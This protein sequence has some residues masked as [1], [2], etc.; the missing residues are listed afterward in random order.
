MPNERLKAL[1]IS[2]SGFIFDPATGSSFNSNAAGL[3]IISYLKAGK[4][5]Q[6]IVQLLLET[7]DVSRAELESDVA[8]F[9]RNLKASHLI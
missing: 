4:T 6:E 3:E 1:A 2:D 9:M 8:D 7:Y 5:G